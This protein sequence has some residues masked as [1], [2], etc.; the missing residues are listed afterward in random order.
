MLEGQKY[1]EGNH[2]ILKRKRTMI[3]DDSQEVEVKYLPNNKIMD[4]QYSKHVDQ[5]TDYLL[6]KPLTF[7]SENKDY[8]TRVQMILGKKFFRTLKN[9]AISSLNSGIAFLYP[10]YNKNS[11]LDF[12][13]F[14]GCDVLPIWSD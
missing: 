1:Y 2:D 14:A 7:H 13:Y 3:D 5:K 6:G 12:K 10:F 11:E 8:E 4:N 9:C